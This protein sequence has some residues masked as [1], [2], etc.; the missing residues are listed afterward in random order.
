VADQKQQK[1]EFCAAIHWSTTWADNPKYCIQFLKLF[2]ANF[3]MMIHLEKTN[4]Y[5]HQ[6]YSGK[7]DD[8]PGPQLVT[9]ERRH[10]F[11]VLILKTGHVKHD[12]FKEYWSRDMVWCAVPLSILVSSNIIDFFTFS[13]FYIA[14]TM[15]IPLTGTEKI[16]MGYGN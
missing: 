9:L 2:F 1:C 13:S 4:R 7:G 8:N 12:T 15:A 10:L 3:L 11:P 5:C 6:Y 14:K 16:M